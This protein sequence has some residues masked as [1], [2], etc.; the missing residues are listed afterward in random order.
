M[1]GKFVSGRARHPT[2]AEQFEE[3][4]RRAIDCSH[5]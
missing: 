4:G 3:L 5:D 2:T 1:V